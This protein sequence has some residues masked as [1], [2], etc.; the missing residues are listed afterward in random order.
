MPQQ[1]GQNFFDP[2]KSNLQSDC[3]FRSNSTRS[4]R[5][6]RSRRKQKNVFVFFLRRVIK[7]G[8]QQGRLRTG[9][10]ASSWKHAKNFVGEN[11][12]AYYY[13]LC[14]TTSPVEGRPRDVQ[15]NPR[16]V[17]GCRQS[18][19]GRPPDVKRGPRGVHSVT[20]T[21]R[22]VPAMSKQIPGTSRDVSRVSRD[23]P[24]M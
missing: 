21:A 9:N 1:S 11:L 16:D 8:V 20:G 7:N 13:Y 10:F 5:I 14:Q 4:A 18:V 12:I 17:Q 22:D 2:S 3:V 23:V 15:T 19:Q 24:R 6:P